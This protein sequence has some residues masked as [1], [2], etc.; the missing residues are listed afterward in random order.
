LNKFLILP[1]ALR[2]SGMGL[3]HAI[4]AVM[5]VNASGTQVAIADVNGDATLD[6]L[7][8]DYINSKVGLQVGSVPG[9]GLANDDPWQSA[10]LC[11]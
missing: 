10:A 2:L 3:E 11:L 6:V 4:S 8:S 9:V 5:L 7:V 1:S